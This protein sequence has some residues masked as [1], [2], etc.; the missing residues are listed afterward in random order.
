M[1]FDVQIAGRPA[2]GHAQN[3]GHAS[4]P[5]RRRLTAVEVRRGVVSSAIRAGSALLGLGGLGSADGWGAVGGP[6]RGLSLLHATPDRPAASRS[7]AGTARPARPCRPALLALV[8]R[9][10]VRADL[11]A[12]LGPGAPG[13]E[14]VSA[15]QCTVATNVLGM[16]VRLHL[17]CLP[18][19]GLLDGVQ[20][21]RPGYPAYEAG[22]SRSPQELLVGLGGP[23]LSVSSS[24]APGSSA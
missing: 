21:S 16:D 1:R 11:H 23:I 15:G 7:R 24:S 13:R 5:L 22:P 20:G 12:Q 19:L 14:R 18:C 2:D 17:R 4:S 10:A 3:R 6:A 9:V 8:E